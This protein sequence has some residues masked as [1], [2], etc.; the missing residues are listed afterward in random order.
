MYLTE[1]EQFWVGVD[2][3]DSDNDKWERDIE[4]VRRVERSK[5][6]VHIYKSI[7]KNNHQV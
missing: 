1:D 2:G 4:N 6:S 7:I 3:D 5:R